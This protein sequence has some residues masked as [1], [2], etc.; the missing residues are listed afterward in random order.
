MHCSYE[1]SYALVIYLLVIRPNTRYT[2]KHQDS[3][4]FI[5]RQSNRT[6]YLSKT[7]GFYQFKTSKIKI[8]IA[9]SDPNTVG[10]CDVKLPDLPSA[11]NFNHTDSTTT[12]V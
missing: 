7:L 2:P 11:L 5:H 8:K 9:I 4:S 10:G 3:L 1:T 6:V 12:V